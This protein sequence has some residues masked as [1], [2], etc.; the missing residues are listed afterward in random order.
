MQA[1]MFLRIVV[2]AI[3]IAFNLEG[4][5]AAL[6]AG[7][8]PSAGD[9]QLFEQIM[10]MDAEIRAKAFEAIFRT[11]SGA[12]VPALDA[13]RNGLLERRTDG[14]LVIYLSRQEVAGRNVFPIAD[15]WTLA[16]LTE[17]DGSPLYA[18]GIGKAMLK[19]ESADS[20]KLS[21]LIQVLSIYHPN[22]ERRRDALIE[23]GSRADTE[24]LPDI[25]AQLQA[26]P[27]GELATTLRE[28]IAR[29][30]L[31]TGNSDAKA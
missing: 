27:D 4:R 2:L 9:Q 11:K 21:R 20:E 18:D 29:I 3:L 19:P 5:A 10:S 13:Y 25:Q 1:R 26:E 14:R 7:S 17:A 28:T 6:Q 23:A 16:P 8:A 22:L 31:A 30:E 12:L 15:G 24:A